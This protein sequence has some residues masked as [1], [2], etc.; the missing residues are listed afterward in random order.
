MSETLPRVINQQHFGFQTGNWYG[1]AGAVYPINLSKEY[2]YFY[3]YKD[4]TTTP[5]WPV[6]ENENDYFRQV[7]T[8]QHKLVS[9][10]GD[11]VA[12]LNGQYTIQTQHPVFFIGGGDW[13]PV[14]QYVEDRQQVESQLINRL[15]DKL[16]DQKVNLGQAFA[17]RAQTAKLVTSSALKITTSLRR[18]RNF[19]IPGAIRELT[20]SYGYAESR[21][22]R[23]VGAAGGIPEQWLALQYGWKPLLGDVK[24]AC[25]ELA[26]L[27][28]EE[29]PLMSVEASFRKKLPPWTV[30]MDAFEYNPPIIK[31]RERGTIAGRGRLVAACSSSLAQAAGRTGIINPYAVTWELLPWSFVVDWFLPVGAFLSRVNFDSGL[32]FKTGF[33]LTKVEDYWDWKFGDGGR[34]VYGNVDCK[35]SGG[36]TRCSVMHY[37]RNGLTGFPPIPLPSFKDP[38]SYAHMANA[39]ALMATSMGRKGAYDQIDFGR[40]G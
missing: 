12:D 5:G 27:L 10:R 1:L 40:L 13:L 34:R 23:L 30:T 2:T 7:V 22:S 6:V 31:S 21:S 36:G 28:L 4:G 29:P 20:G 14:G 26:N 19:D 17:E 38:F 8:N 16:L 33:L 9:L 39:L 25:D 32:V 3:D 35:Y 37:V 15:T 11:G 24:G 18:L